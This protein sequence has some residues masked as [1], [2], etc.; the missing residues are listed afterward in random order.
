MEIKNTLAY[1]FDGKNVV[2][3]GT[4]CRDFLENGTPTKDQTDI[5]SIIDWSITFLCEKAGI[6]M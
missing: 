5:D 4:C 2:H 6:Q 1:V 3:T